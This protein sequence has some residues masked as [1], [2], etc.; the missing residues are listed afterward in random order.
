[1]YAFIG[2]KLEKVRKE[3][4]EAQREHKATEEAKRLRQEASKIESIINDDFDAFRKRLQK[5][6]AAT[7]G[8]GFDLSEAQKPVGG[9]G[10]DD[11]LYGGDEPAVETAETGAL[12]KTKSGK[13]GAKSKLPRRLN[14]LVE[15]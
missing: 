15:P 10:E 5:V 3:L 12:G 13:G 1:M 8:S 2:P 7:A 6:R 4:V 11:F 9:A 14:P